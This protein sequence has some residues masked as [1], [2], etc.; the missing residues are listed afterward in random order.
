MELAPH[1]LP[2]RNVVDL[3]F[4][5]IAH[6]VDIPTN[7]Q[8]YTQY[9]QCKP[10]TAALCHFLTN[11]LTFNEKKL[12]I[13][14]GKRCRMSEPLDD[15]DLFIIK[16]LQ[17]DG[18]K[19]FDKIASQAN[20]SARTISAR[21]NRLVDDGV[22]NITAV[23]N[24]EKVGYPVL[25]TVFVETE[26]NRTKAVADLLAAMNEVAFVGLTSGDPDIYAS[27]RAESNSALATFMSEKMP[28]IEGVRR[29]R[30]LLVLDV[31]KAASR[32]MIPQRSGN[33]KGNGTGDK[34][35]RV[36]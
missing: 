1:Y 18:R 6:P 27:I 20:V 32:W 28:A 30:L 36:R 14:F 25:A 3:H 13:C 33:G 10:G 12:I 29:A 9:E 19:P 21:V 4:C 16:S 35:T 24:P 11:L 7:E 22:I 34:R 8:L 31:V 17:E 23:V 26:I 15:L 5:L 2:T